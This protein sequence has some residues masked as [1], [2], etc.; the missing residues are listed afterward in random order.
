MTSPNRRA[1]S[2]ALRALFA[3]S[4][5]AASLGGA[6]AACGITTDP[7]PADAATRETGGQETSVPGPDATADVAPDATTGPD[8]TADATTDASVDATPDATTGP[9]A[10]ADAAADATPDATADAIADAADAADAADTAVPPVPP[11]VRFVGRW[12]TRSAQ[13]PRAAYPASR[14]MARFEGTEV[15]V[16]MNNTTGFSGGPARYDVLIDGVLEPTQLVTVTG[17][18]SYPLASGLAP[19]VH[20]VELLKRTEGNLGVTT[21][22]GFTFGAGGTLLSPPPTPDRRIEVIADSTIDGYGVEG[23]GPSCPTTEQVL[24][25][26]SPRLGVAGLVGADLGADTIM[27]AYSG[28]GLY[29]NGYLPD[30][31]TMGVLYPRTLP[32]DATSAWDFTRFVPDV[33]IVSLG[34]TDYDAA[35]PPAPL[36]GFTAKYDELI[37]KVR[38][39]APDAHI[40]LTIYAQLKD[41][42]PAGYFTRRNVRAAINTVVANRAALGDTKVYLHEWPESVPSQETGCQYHGNIALHQSL[43]N[44][45][46]P[47]IRAKTGW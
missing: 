14:V 24:A 2:P 42:Y 12:D 1:L 13:G 45:I 27:V 18:A 44:H 29:Q 23:M 32:D 39:H 41:V 36:A 40:F 34:G 37:T 7:G 5:L 21:F 17:V 9:D 6:G 43:A 16:R 19:G 10:T 26:H 4:L 28:K 11:A 15:S 35:N 8:A 46:L 31:A 20:S 33:V 22:M 25:S 30:T 38:L 47:V 3:A